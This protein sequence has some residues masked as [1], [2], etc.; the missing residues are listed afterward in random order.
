MQ[1]CEACHKMTDQ[2]SVNPTVIYSAMPAHAAHSLTEDSSKLYTSFFDS[3]ES[4]E[5]GLTEEICDS[6]SQRQQARNTF[7]NFSN[8]R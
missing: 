8:T 2:G 5:G 3:L 1:V 7:V 4:Q 6:I